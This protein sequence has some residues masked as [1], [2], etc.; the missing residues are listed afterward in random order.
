MIMHIIQQKL[1]LQCKSVELPAA[2][3]GTNLNKRAVLWQHINI[4][5]TRINLEWLSKSVLEDADEL[6]SRP[7]CTVP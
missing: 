5:E 1:K 4:L 6:I 7:I 2:A 3:S